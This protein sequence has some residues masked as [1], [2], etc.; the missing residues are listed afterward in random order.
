MYGKDT[1]EDN[2]LF[3]YFIRDKLLEMKTLTRGK[4]L[5]RCGISSAVMCYLWVYALGIRELRERF[6]VIQRRLSVIILNSGWPS[7]L[8]IYCIWVL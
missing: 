6:E 5:L 7:S 4:S 1:A 2:Q 3:F 8:W